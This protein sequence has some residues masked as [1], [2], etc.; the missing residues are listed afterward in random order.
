MARWVGYCKVG[1]VWQGGRCM[2]VWVGY[3]KVGGVW[4]GGC[5]SGR[6]VG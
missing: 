3:G 1:G 6:L 4:H 2:T 5:G